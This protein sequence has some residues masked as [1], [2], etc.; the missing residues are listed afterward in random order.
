LVDS[1]NYAAKGQ[2]AQAVGAAR[3][4]REWQPYSAE[5]WLQEGLAEE[6]NG[7]FKQAA[8]M[9][10]GAI[11]REPAGWQPWL[12]LAGLEAK[13]GNNSAALRDYR[14]ARDLNPTSPLFEAAN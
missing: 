12:V 9:L 5:A 7:N 14:R 3:S 2:S 10:R 6:A 8:V 4:A 13:Q 11:K 1:R